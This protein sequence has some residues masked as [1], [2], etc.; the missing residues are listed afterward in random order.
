VTRGAPDRY[1]AAV[2]AM[3]QLR[4]GARRVGELPKASANGIRAGADRIGEL[5]SRVGSRLG[6]AT[7]KASRT[8]TGLPAKVAQ[9]VRRDTPEGGTAAAGPVQATSEEGVLDRAR[10]H[11][12]YAAAIAGGGLLLIAWIAWA[13]YVTTAH[14][15]TAGL[16][17]VISWPVLLSALALISLPFVG[18]FLLVRRL[19]SGGDGTATVEAASSGEADDEDDEDASD[20]DE[21]TEESDED[22]PDASAEG[23][24]EGDEDES[25][26]DESDEDEDEDAEGEAED[27]D[28]DGSDENPDASA[29]AS[30]SG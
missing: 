10:S 29:K 30:F 12:R 19:S 6:D 25:D 16:G 13:I 28:E 8:V 15:A 18:A 1:L 7:G 11:P 27:S 5:P 23:E 2:G 26:E 24:E 3:D 17:V 4:R 20:D 9:R 21:G 14:G 22:D